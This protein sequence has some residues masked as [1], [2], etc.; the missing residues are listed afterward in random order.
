[1]RSFIEPKKENIELDVA[2]AAI[3][4]LSQETQTETDDTLKTNA[5]L[6]AEIEKLNRF[7]K[8]MEESSKL[9]NLSSVASIPSTSTAQLGS[10]VD[11]DTIE[12]RHLI[13]YQERMAMLENKIE[14]FESSGDEQAKLLSKRLEHEVQ[15]ASKVN[16]LQ[17]AVEKLRQKTQELEENNCELEEIENETR[18][19]CQKL[20]EE[21]EVMNQR[22]SELEMTKNCYQDKFEEARDN[23][24]YMEECLQATEERIKA[25]ETR[26]KELMR[27]LQLSSSFIPAVALFQ[28]WKMK[29]MLLPPMIKTPPPPQ[30]LIEIPED[31]PIHQKVLELQTREKQ[32][33]QN[34]NDLNRAYQETLEN[35]DN[36]W[37]QMEKEYKDKISLYEK[38]EASLR[39]KVQQLE[40]RLLRDT[41]DANDRISSLEETEYQLKN[42]AGK[43]NRDLKEQQKKNTELLDELQSA[44]D[45]NQKLQAY[46]NGP[47]AD[48][49]EREKKKL[50]R[51]E[52][53]LQIARNAL[54][55]AENAHK[56]EQILLKR[57]LQKMHKELKN[58]EVTNGELREEVETLER[59]IIELETYHVGDK[60]RIQ[61]LIDELESKSQYQQ[62]N[63]KPVRAFKQQPSTP[64]KSLAQELNQ[65]PQPIPRQKTVPIIERCDRTSFAFADAINK[66][67]VIF[68]FITN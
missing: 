2:G 66:F 60:N 17:D 40:K 41:E 39:L 56:N 59:R 61:E 34:I 14:I 33:T 31:H 50:R 13:F 25:L 21:F 36:L 9:T 62:Q 68:K 24:E 11:C 19:R 42:R 43:L 16:Q 7:R 67:E 8:K 23:V 52:E 63:I 5:E 53:D 38:L 26:E 35:A 6:Y 22:N 27:R 30:K 1:L 46:I 64:I 20:E 10:S 47:A 44:K 4:T 37:A 65:K 55:D 12:R 29:K 57:Q 45:E 48:N 28:M 54:K 32:L 18:L 58:F 51:T 15:L 3:S 49:I